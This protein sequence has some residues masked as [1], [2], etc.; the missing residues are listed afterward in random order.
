MPL[1]ERARAEVSAHQHHGRLNNLGGIHFEQHE[2]AEARRA[3][4]ESLAIGRELGSKELEAFAV[5]GLG[6]VSLNVGELEAAGR[7]LR[8]ALVLF[9]EL[10]SQDRV[11]SCCT[12]LAALARATGDDAEAARLLGA[13]AGLR[14]GTGTTTDFSE[15]EIAEQTR[16][17]VE[18][19]L[20]S[21]AFAAALRAGSVAK[22]QVVAEVL[23]GRVSTLSE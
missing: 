2:W 16:S 19:S 12:Y 7:E 15:L 20:G 5:L 9:A 1:D 8:A 11:G 14:D 6:S 10:G 3:Y 13:A 18:A 23:G 21:G 17:A 4:D 22:E